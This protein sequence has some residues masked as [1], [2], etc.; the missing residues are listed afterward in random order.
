MCVLTLVLL[1]SLT[2]ACSS[3]KDPS[4]TASAANSAGDTAEDTAQEPKGVCIVF[5]SD[6]HCGIDEGFGYVGLQQ[7]RNILDSKGYTTILVDNGDFVQGEAVGTL[8]KGEELIELMND[9]PYDVVTIGNHE[10]D[11][12]MDQFFALMGKAKFQITDCNF[13]KEGELLFPP[14]VILEA[15]GLRIAFVGITTPTTLTTSTP[16]YF[17]NED[18]EFIYDFM[19]D[20][21]GEKLYQA[22]QK[23]VD[24]ARAEG[25]D[26]VYALAHLGL[27]DSDSPW[28]Y[29]DVISNTN[30]IDVLLDGHSHDTEQIVMKNKDG[31][32]VTRSAPGTKLNCVGYSYISLKDGSIDTGIWSW[33]ND[34]CAA[35]ILGVKNELSSAVESAL[36]VL[37]EKLGQVV[38]STSV[39]LTIYD[40]EAKDSSGN[41]VRMV[42]RAETNLADLCTDAFREILG[43]DIAILNGGAIR[44]SIAKGDITYGDIL[45]VFPFENQCSVIEATGQQILDALEWGARSVPDE[46]GAF[47]QVSGLTYEIDSS[48]TSSCTSDESNMFTGVSG[49]RRVKNVM[50]GDEPIDPDKTYTVGSIDYVLIKNGDGQTAF[51][52]CT[53]VKSMVM[54]DN[55]LLIEYITN[56]LDGTIGD[57]YEDLTGQGRIT[58]L[59]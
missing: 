13:N 46:N 7:I 23:A 47:L 30:G 11:Y 20:K 53:V 24:D 8:T 16:A 33:P 43:S 55:Q 40:P 36:Q 57:G 15:A 21:T 25:V 54:V 2:G 42:R 34:D 17:Q 6:V 5:T 39:E 4:G 27:N 52:G 29:A 37:Q 38:A 51:N 50:I 26:Y 35:D 18:G 19:N 48:I 49:E 58:I 12:G 32:E 3:G 41:P 56:N 45:D 1:T 14:Y 44:N 22:V 9:L 10:F 31:K 28:T 59:E